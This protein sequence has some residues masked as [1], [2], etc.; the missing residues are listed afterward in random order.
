MSTTGSLYR[1]ARFSA[2][3]RA[4]LRGPYALTRLLFRRFLFRTWN[5]PLR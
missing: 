2:L 5:K 3:L 1:A 4:I